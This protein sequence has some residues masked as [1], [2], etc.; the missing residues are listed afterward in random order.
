[1]SSIKA[2]SIYISI[3]PI[4]D[5]IDVASEFSINNLEPKYFKC[6]IYLR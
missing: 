6:D 5:P 4:E 1:M 2:I 3:D